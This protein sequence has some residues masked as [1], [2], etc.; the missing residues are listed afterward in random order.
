MKCKSIT[1]SNGRKRWDTGRYKTHSGGGKRGDTGRVVAAESIIHAHAH[2]AVRDQE[3][4]AGL[5][6]LEQYFSSQCHYKWAND[7]SNIL[8]KK[9]FG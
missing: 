8:I 4:F 9:T 5:I 1:H 7:P 3:R 2:F 6:K